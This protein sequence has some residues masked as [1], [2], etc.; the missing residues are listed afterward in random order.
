MSLRVCL[1]ARIQNVAK[2]TNIDRRRIDR[3]RIDLPRRFVENL[4]T[5][6]SDNPGAWRVGGAKRSAT[7]STAARARS[8]HV[9]TLVLVDC[10]LL[11]AVARLQERH[12]QLDDCGERLRRAA[13]RRA[14]PRAS[15]LAV[16]DAR[17]RAQSNK[18]RLAR[19]DVRHHVHS[20]A[21]AL[22]ASL[23]RRSK[24]SWDAF[25]A[26]VVTFAFGCASLVAQRV[27]RR[28]STRRVAPLNAALSGRTATASTEFC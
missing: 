24:A 16:G 25:A 28:S 19:P 23:P 8:D 26:P 2:T 22:S 18:L 15:M 12:H 4:S 14:K 9:A 10:R 3:R 27:A 5:F 20:D 17:A 13:L 6:Y 11:D 21:S 7:T 1:C